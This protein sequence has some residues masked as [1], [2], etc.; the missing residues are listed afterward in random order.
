MQKML[1]KRENCVWSFSRKLH[2]INQLGLSDETLERIEIV[3]LCVSLGG[4]RE[5]RRG[6]GSGYRK[7]ERFC[8]LTA[9]VGVDRL[10]GVLGDPSTEDTGTI[11]PIIG[12]L[13]LDNER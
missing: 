10:V 2:R 7:E 9:D 5:K 4:R 6:R 12:V 13:S 8:G 1:E 3:L 11:R